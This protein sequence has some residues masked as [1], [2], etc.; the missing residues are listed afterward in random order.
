MGEG[1][2]LVERRDDKSERRHSE[3]RRTG[4]AMAGARAAP[5]CRRGAARSTA[6]SIEVAKTW[7]FWPPCSRGTTDCL[8]CRAALGRPCRTG[9]L[10]LSEPLRHREELIGIAIRGLSQT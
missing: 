4:L 3:H 8:M 1:G 9:V 5:L 2:R 6:P 10:S 7:Y